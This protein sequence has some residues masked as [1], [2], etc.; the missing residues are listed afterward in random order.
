MEKN[1]Y[2]AYGSF[3]FEKIKAPKPKSNNEPKSTKTVGKD[4]LRGGKK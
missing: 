3:G 4:D 2:S 1:N